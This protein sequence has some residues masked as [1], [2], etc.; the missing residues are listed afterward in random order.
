M[1][2]YIVFVNGLCSNIH[3]ADFP[4]PCCSHKKDEIFDFYSPES[5]KQTLISKFMCSR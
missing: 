5:P 2:S 4:L 3:A 1:Y